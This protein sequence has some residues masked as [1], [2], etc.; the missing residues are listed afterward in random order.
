MAQDE[1]TCVIF[2]MPKEA[3]AKGG[4]DDIVPL[5]QLAATILNKAERAKR[6]I[7]PKTQE[8]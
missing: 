6:T 7:H 2:G 5:P 3:I 4:V 1:A 8:I